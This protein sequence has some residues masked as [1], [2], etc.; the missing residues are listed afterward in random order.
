M[1]RERGITGVFEQ[2]IS[3]GWYFRWDRLMTHDSWYRI[4]KVFRYI[5][6][7]NNSRLDNMSTETSIWKV[8]SA[9]FE[10]YSPVGFAENMLESKLRVVMSPGFARNMLESKL[11]TTD[12]YI[13][14]KDSDRVKIP[15]V[16]NENSRNTLFVINWKVFWIPRIQSRYRHKHGTCLDSKP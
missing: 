3:P 5:L 4:I 15:G 2:Q 11:M 13:T 12:W 10:R 14:K 1:S 6:I 16:P 9:D 8:D 7:S